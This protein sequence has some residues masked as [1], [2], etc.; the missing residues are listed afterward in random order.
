MKLAG[1]ETDD[2]SPRERYEAQQETQEASP[3]GRKPMG[4]KPAELWPWEYRKVKK[5]SL[6][7]A[8]VAGVRHALKLAFQ[9]AKPLDNSVNS[10]KLQT[11]PDLNQRQNISAPPAGSNTPGS[12]PASSSTQTAASDMPKLSAPLPMA[13]AKKLALRE[14]KSALGMQ[15]RTK[16]S[17]PL[18]L[19]AKDIARRKTTPKGAPEVK[20]T[21][22]AAEGPAP[23]TQTSH[24]PT[25]TSKPFSSVPSALRQPTSESSRAVGLAPA[26]AAP[27]PT[28][29]PLTNP[30]QAGRIESTRRV[31]DGTQLER[32]DGEQKKQAED[33]KKIKAFG[34]GSKLL[35]A[36]P[37]A[38]EKVRKETLRRMEEKAAGPKTNLAKNTSVG[39]V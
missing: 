27:A 30:E 26:L 9:A 7:E 16:V 18:S 39:L 28:P 36:D 5:A 15:P 14:T 29:A 32:H 25:S 23:S 6:R 1:R 38:A 8:Y 10:T 17:V 34:A 20:K 31:P 24:A 11:Y 22:I 21:K 13:L 4:I 3:I 19:E 33:A 35:P 37:E 2:A 12:Q